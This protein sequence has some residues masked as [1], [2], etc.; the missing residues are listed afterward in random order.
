MEC[1]CACVCVCTHAHTHMHAL[2]MACYGQV[3][4]AI[5]PLLRL[6]KIC[7]K[8]PSVSLIL[9]G[10]KRKGFWQHFS[11]S[12]QEVQLGTE[13]PGPVWW[14]RGRQRCP[15]PK[16]DINEVHRF[17]D[18]QSSVF[19]VIYKYFFII[20]FLRYIVLTRLK[21]KMTIPC[22][23]F[24]CCWVLLPRGSQLLPLVMCLLIS[25][26]YAQT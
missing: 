18:I 7:L 23:T 12:F 14:W 9:K 3:P 19:P 26:R 21:P 6:R 16:E 13:F 25:K 11:H 24:L 10:T 20:T 17:G 22:P 2:A 4:S 8:F 15:I 1:V 5:F